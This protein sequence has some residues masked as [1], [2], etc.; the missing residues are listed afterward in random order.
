MNPYAPQFTSAQI[1]KAANME[2]ANFRAYL[3]KG[4]WRI[5]GGERGGMER[6][7]NGKPHLFTVYDALGY[8][9]ARVLVERGA[10]PAVAFET[11]MRDFAHAGDEAR[12]PGDVFDVN[13]KGMTW[14][15]YWPEARTGRCLAMKSISEF[16]Y[17]TMRSGASEFWAIP[18]NALRSRVLASL[19][20][21]DDCK[22]VHA[23]GGND[24]SRKVK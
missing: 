12:A 13:T 21:D 5:I 24:A 2:N 11:A 1:A 20:L 17:P 18:L 7:A 15:V 10:P 19:G 14:F 6:E 23:D 16:P 3:R 8:A 4:D 9:L 22:P